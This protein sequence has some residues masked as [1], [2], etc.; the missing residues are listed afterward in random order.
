M[1]AIARLTD[2]M[3]TMRRLQIAALLLCLATT[4]LAVADDARAWLERMNRAVD[5]LNYEGIFVHIHGGR[6]ETHYVVHRYMDGRVSERI[7]SL[8]GAGREIIRHEEEVTCIL[9]DQQ[10]VLVENRRDMSPLVSA[11][12]IYS[13]AVTEHYALVLRGRERIAGRSTRVLVIKPQ[14]AYRYGYQL[15]LDQATAMPLK[16]QLQDEQGRVVEQILF[17]SISLPEYIPASALSPTTSTEGFTWLRREDPEQRRDAHDS[18][19]GWRAARLPAGFQLAASSVHMLAD[20]RFPVQHLVYSDGLASVSVFVED[21]RAEHEQ[22]EGEWP[23]GLAR[24]GGA[25]AY[26]LRQAGRLVTVVGEVPAQTVEAIARSVEEGDPENDDLG[27]A[28]Q[29]EPGQDDQ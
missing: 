6:A 3:S 1:T 18:K 23:L 5:E 2:A 27:D 19:V 16:S 25:N 4:G 11:L 12:P 7:I 17:T 15:W 20:S 28:G 24:V 13:D 29:P 26:S 21:P 9:P 22:A 14:D 8:D 10:T